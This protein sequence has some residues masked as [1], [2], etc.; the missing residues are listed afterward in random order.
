[1]KY[2]TLLWYSFLYVIMMELALS[3]FDTTALLVVSFSLIS[4]MVFSLTSCVLC[5]VY[6][7]ILVV[8]IIVLC[9]VQLGIVYSPVQI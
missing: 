9:Y 8:Y 7:D 4:F 2:M 5:Y 3:A 1:M 6:I